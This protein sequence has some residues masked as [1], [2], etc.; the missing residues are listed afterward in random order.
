[1][2]AVTSA[3]AGTHLSS[4][5]KDRAIH[6]AEEHALARGLAL[7]AQFGPSTFAPMAAPAKATG[8]NNNVLAQRKA[9]SL[10][11]RRRQPVGHRGLEVRRGLRL[12]RQ[13]ARGRLAARVH[14]CPGRRAGGSLA[15]GRRTARR[16]L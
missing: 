13:G 12:R 9:T 7:Q 1:M 16:L 3:M 5:A 10:G 6:G 14:A 15:R 4:G 11:R 8:A 2:C